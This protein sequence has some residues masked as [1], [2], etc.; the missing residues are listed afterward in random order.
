MM[1]KLRLGGVWV[2]FEHQ[3]DDVLLR[4]DDV[5]ETSAALSRVGVSARGLRSL[6]PRMQRA[7]LDNRDAAMTRLRAAGVMVHHIY[8]MRGE[9]ACEFLIGE[10]LFLTCK[11][12]AGLQRIVNE[13]HL[14]VLRDYGRNQVLA[15][16]TSETGC[17]VL[18]LAMQLQEEHVHEVIDCEPDFY[19]EL[20]RFAP[21]I[22]ADPLFTQQWHLHAP[23]DGVELLAGADI[24]ATAAWA[25][26]RGSRDVVICVADDGCDLTHPDFSGEGK[27][28]GSINVIPGPNGQLR[29]EANVSPRG[30]DYHGTP[31]TGVAIA[32]INGQGTVGVAPGCSLLA[33]RFP[34]NLSDSQMAALFERISLQADVV[35]CSWGYPPTNAPM[36]SHLKQTIARLAVTGG[37]RGRGLVFCVAAGNNNAPLHDPTNT[38][39]YRFRDEA[40]WHQYSGP[41]DRWIATH[42][43]VIVV[44][45][46]TSLKKRSAFSSWGKEVTVCAPTDN[47]DDQEITAVR[48]RGV[49]TTDNEQAGAGF[50]P[51]IYTSAFGG[52]SSA[53]P[54]VA[55]VC[56]LMLSANPELSARKVKSLLQQTADKSLDLVSET[57]V[58][59]DGRFTNGHSLWFGAGKVRA[60]LAV[61]AALASNTLQATTLTGQGTASKIPLRPQALVTSV[62]CPNNGTIQQLRVEVSLSHPRPRDVEIALQVPDGRQVILFNAGTSTGQPPAVFGTHNVP[63]LQALLGAGVKGKYSLLLSDRQAGGRGKLTRWQ[64]DV[65]ISMPPPGPAAPQKKTTSARKSAR[66]GET[67]K[68]G[69]SAIAKPKVTKTKTVSKQKSKTRRAKRT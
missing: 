1:A 43:D 34:L 19:R 65:V 29:Y 53:T 66:A 14:Q 64:L 46:C 32:E 7:T 27:V 45:G 55:G 21:F 61:A 23:E 16:V 44:S 36:S 5:S 24:G 4:G 42:P 25:L 67:S 47:W 63:A 59:S 20:K 57:P 60:D 8:R 11:T 39:A 22:P 26:S 9:P 58:N 28:R 54:T 56:G 69:D 52:T 49:V 2:E 37:R 33:V 35:S 3:D 51:G 30:N 68:R 31:C 40:S 38:T 62:N 6:R 17:N 13:C 15:S 12:G 18:K 10:R 48:G 50:S 41:I